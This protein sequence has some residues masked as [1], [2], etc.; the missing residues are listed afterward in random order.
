MERR[1]DTFGTVNLSHNEWDAEKVIAT[2]LY[3]IG[4]W[5]NGDADKEKV[6]TDI[7][8]DQIDVT[9]RTFLG[10]TLACAPCT[11]C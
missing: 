8:D 2:G 4:N 10:L 9:S 6:H 7:I 5:G 11:T 3:A 1:T